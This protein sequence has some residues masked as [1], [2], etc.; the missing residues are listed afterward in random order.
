MI[1]VGASK[2][3]LASIIGV[4]NLLGILGTENL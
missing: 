3:A 2:S 1:D 4:M